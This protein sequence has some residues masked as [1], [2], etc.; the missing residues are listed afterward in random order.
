MNIPAGRL[1]RPVLV[2]IYVVVSK[3]PMTESAGKQTGGF[4][5]MKTLKNTASEFMIVPSEFP[6]GQLLRLPC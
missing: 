3:M 6:L 1:C 4:W 5:K 2:G